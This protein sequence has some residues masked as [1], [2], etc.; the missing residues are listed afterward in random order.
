MRTRFLLSL[1]GLLAGAVL[2]GNIF[3]AQLSPEEALAR[4][5]ADAPKRMQA[6]GRHSMKLSM[7]LR[8]APDA[9]ADLY[10]FSIPEGGYIVAGADDCS[11]ALLG[12]SDSGNFES[13]EMPPAMRYWLEE[14]G[15]QIAASRGRSGAP[16]AKAEE[17]A[18][19]APMLTSKWDQRT[20]YN[21]KCP[22]INGTQSVTGCVATAMAQIMNYHEWPE[23]GNGSNAY[24]WTPTG[25]T[26]QTISLDF[27]SITFDWENMADVYSDGYTAAQ[28]DAVATLMYACGV[29]LNMIYSTSESGAA[30]EYVPRSLLNYFDYDK[31]MSCLFRDYYDADEWEDIIYDQLAKGQPVQYAGRNN[32][33]GHSFVC[34]GYSADGYYHFN[35]G[36]SGL[37]DGYF[38]LDALNPED[39]GTGGST[40]GYNYFQR[41]IINIAPASGASSTTFNILIDGD[42][43]ITQT[44][45]KTGS[46]VDVKSPSGSSI[47]NFSLGGISG[48]FGL[49]ISPNAATGGDIIY[50]SI[51]A[52][53][54]DWQYATSISTYQCILPSSIPDGTYFVSPAFKDKNGDWHDILVKNNH[55]KY[56]IMTVSA[57]Q[58]E[59]YPSETSYLTV[60]DFEFE[61]ELWFDNYFRMTIHVSNPT[62]QVYSGAIRPYVISDFGTVATCDLMPV[63]LAGGESKVLT[64]TGC[65][66][67]TT[68][69]PTEGSYYFY[70]TDAD[71]N[72]IY[73]DKTSVT[74][75]AN[76]GQTLNLTDLR[77]G[78]QPLDKITEGVVEFSADI[79]CEKGFFG[80]PLLFCLFGPYPKDGSDNIPSENISLAPVFINEGETITVT[81]SFSL[82]GSEEGNTYATGVYTTDG[83]PI[84]YKFLTVFGKSDGLTGITSEANGMILDG[85]TLKINGHDQAEISIYH[86]D[87][88]RVLSASGV[89]TLDLSALPHG[90]YIAVMHTPDGQTSRMSLARR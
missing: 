3:A 86:A 54:D 15:R 72:E 52:E 71:T 11:P 65:I 82:K 18:A 68:T 1:G 79:T 90:L 80:G 84:G 69:N 57:G 74:V 10:V 66:K 21:G 4:V 19:I 34:D 8:N 36:W 67:S 12:Y 62:E 60:S 25:G 38:L 61:T 78:E 43:G 29:S 51:G 17:R 27:S 63:N 75:H 16:A 40:A 59:F 24:S 50:T 42:F 89:Q 55:I 77:A 41:A 88:I 83:T 6:H 56:L 44:S 9:P 37:S 2:C 45:A 22:T 49:K 70:I 76:D 31:S 5:F 39:Q 14:Y 32:D 23:K 53:L 85:D 46:R 20:P 58:C 81:S 48:T 30:T 35:W 33:V 73:S 87:G 26:P 64:Y 28:G 13:A 47:A 7:T